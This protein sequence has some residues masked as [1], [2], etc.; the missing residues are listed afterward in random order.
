MN[1]PLPIAIGTLSASRRGA[2]LLFSGVLKMSFVYLSAALSALC[3]K[4]LKPLTTKDH[5]GNHKGTQREEIKNSTFSTAPLR[6]EL[7]LSQNIPVFLLLI[8]DKHKLVI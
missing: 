2:S 8:P 4:I 5:K 1:S 7:M 6:V 3:G